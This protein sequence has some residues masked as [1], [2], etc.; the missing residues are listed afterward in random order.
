VIW[1]IA[2]K[3]FLLNLMTFKFAAGGIVCI[4]LMA[5]FMPILA[6]DY[7]RRLGQYN[8]AVRA[9]E[10]ELRKVK[11]YK[12]ITPTIYRPPAIL[13]VVSEGLDKQLGKSAKIELGGVSDISTASDQGNPFLS[14]FPTLDVALIFKIVMSVLALLVAYDTISGEREQGTL[15]LILSSR[16]GRYQI[17][18]GKLGAGLLTLIIPTTIAFIVG[19]LIL[20]FF[21]TVELTSLD[22]T[23]IVLMYIATLFFISAMYNIGLLCSS[24]A[25]TSAISLVSGLFIW[26]IFMVVIPNGSVYLAHYLRPTEA[27]EKLNVK[28]KS[29][30]EERDNKI[31]ELTKDLK[32]GGSQSNA[33]GAFGH[34]YVLMCDKTFMADMLKQHRA[35]EP[36]KITYGKKIFEIQQEYLRNIIKQKY[37]AGVIA[38]IS[39]MI[40]YEDVMSALSGTDLGNFE[41]FRNNVE[42]YTNEVIEYIRSN[43]ENFSLS[44]YFTPAKVED[45]LEV[46]K[47]MAHVAQAADRDQAMKEV[48]EWYNKKVAQTPSVDLQD[49]PRF[50]YGPES[51]VKILHR[52]IPDLAL[53]VFVNTLFFTLSFAAFVRYDVRPD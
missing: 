41:Y 34:R 52:A 19:L 36:V 45:Y 23:C 43:T 31:G 50:R 13:S 18:L 5:V 38:Q 30:L 22:W 1:K 40:L 27:K 25:R 2:K 14:I 44:S 3:D 9:N 49:L 17:L 20:Q 29:L 11:V 21:P 24:L 6:K 33:V 35:A 39:P 8:E 28:V 53:L 46:E 47:Q 48:V 37:L 4:V 42:T 16:V 26:V 7:Q 51:L 15:K 12:N 10:A 32:G